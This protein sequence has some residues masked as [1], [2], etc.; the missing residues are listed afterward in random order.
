MNL[1]EQLQ[2]EIKNQ[3]P[4]LVPCGSSCHTPIELKPAYRTI[5]ITRK[6]YFGRGIVTRRYRLAF[7][8]MQF[9]A[10]GCVPVVTWSNQS[11]SSWD[12]L[13]SAPLLPNINAFGKVCMGGNWSNSS[14]AT[15]NDFW[16]TNFVVGEIR[17]PFNLIRR[18]SLKSLRNWQKMSLKS[19]HPLD[20]FENYDFSCVHSL[21]QFIH[22]RL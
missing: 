19:K 22:D 6:K 3:K 21:A 15:C 18:S 14:M 12:G 10:R 11:I 2:S 1:Q 16:L 7:P 17:G 9:C 13:V 5:G 8:Y 4:K 20:V